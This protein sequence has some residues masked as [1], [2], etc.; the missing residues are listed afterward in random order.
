MPLQIQFTIDEN[1]RTSILLR[2]L[3]VLIDV[4]DVMDEINAAYQFDCRSILGLLCAFILIPYFAPCLICYFCMAAPRMSKARKKA[5][6]AF[7]QKST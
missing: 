7:N 5:I 2:D 1:V 4:I 6:T 3:H